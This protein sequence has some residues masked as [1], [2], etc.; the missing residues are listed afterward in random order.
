MPTASTRSRGLRTS[1]LLAGLTAV[2]LLLSAPFAGSLAASA[3]PAGYTASTSNEYGG[4][5]ILPLMTAGEAYTAT[6]TGPQY[7]GPTSWCWSIDSGSLP[8]GI[9]M[10]TPEDACAPTATFSGTPE[11]GEFTF[12]LRVADTAGEMSFILSFEG[13]IESGKSP[14]TT[15]LTVTEVAPYDAIVLTADVVGN[16]VVTGA[17]TGSVEFRDQNNALLDTG[18][19]T[20]GSTTVTATIDRSRVGSDLEVTAVYLGDSDY[21]GSSST[22]LDI[23]IYAPTATG[24]VEWN[25]T[26]VTDATVRLVRASDNAHIDSDDT[27]ADGEFELDPGAITTTS[28][29]ERTYIIEVT[30]AD[31]EVLYQVDGDYNVT[32]YLDAEATGPL[33][34]TASLLVERRS[35]PRWDDD[36]LPR[37]RV[38]VAYSNGVSAESRG[39]VTY[40]VTDGALPAGLTLNAS[41]GAV[42]GTPSECRDADTPFPFGMEGDGELPSCDYDFTITADNG[43]GD[44][45]ERFT[46]TLLPAGVAPT[47]EDDELVDLRE[48]VAVDDGVLAV[49]DPTITYSVTDGTLPAGLTLDPATGAIT[50]TPTTAGPY[51]FTITA[52]NDFGSIDAVFEGDIAAKPDLDLVLEFE[53]GTSVEDASSTISASGLQVGSEYTLTMYST[54]RVLYTGTVDG[55]G[56]FSWVVSLPADTPDGSHRLVLTG[57]AA[58]GTPMSATA[59]FSLSN[60]R[61]TAIS[62]TGPI[63][64]LAFTG[65]DPASGTLA[66]VVLLLVGAGALTVSRRRRT[67]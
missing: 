35:G 55:S 62:Y 4:D 18:V 6:L 54:P 1:R 61:I 10:T 26:P 2:L 51:A 41:T 33:D 60:G 25:G 32:D 9:T 44:V 49:G 16:P 66:A 21:Q 34:W 53:A 24:S 28:D 57:T 23:V 8:V 22:E 15:T 65:A 46:G 38:G 13:V 20:A 63:G 59:W 19:L 40:T 58:D 43:Y 29:A 56:G 45:D 11:A 14:T 67:A 31:D 47:W 52:E 42:T 36:G 5:K 64:G 37:P 12:D 48:D 50:G 27:D 30:F 17:P 39:P 7:G 3:A